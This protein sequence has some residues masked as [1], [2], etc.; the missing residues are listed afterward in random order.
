MRYTILIILSLAIAACKNDTDDEPVDV[1]YSY[2]PTQVGAT[3]IYNVDSITYDDNTGHTTIDTITY[4]YK[5]QIT[6]SFV[7]G[8]GNT[9]QLVSRF[10]R[11]HDTLLW[12]RVTNS[13]VYQTA[14]NAQ[15]VNENIRYVKLVF[16][17]EKSKS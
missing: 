13:T 14:L 5:E 9:A 17:L 12:T 8:A 3:W 15:R 10:Y 6:G 1:G 16:P 2:F 11:D 4:Q 7:D